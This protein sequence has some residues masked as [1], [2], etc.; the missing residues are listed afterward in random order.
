[1]Y[2]WLVFITFHRINSSTQCLGNLA[3]TRSPRL[4]VVSSKIQT[5]HQIHL[6]L[7]S[8]DTYGGPDREEN[9]EEGQEAAAGADVEE[10]VA[11]D[12]SVCC[13]CIS[14]FY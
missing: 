5:Q 6:N 10:A 14:G 11:L 1:M 7:S 12:Q 2:I 4:A 3:V 13:F 8:S 9:E